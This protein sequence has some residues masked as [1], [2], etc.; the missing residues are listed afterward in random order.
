MLYPPYTI[1]TGVLSLIIMTV[2]RGYRVERRREVCHNVTILGPCVL[3]TT[4]FITE[5][6]SGEG[7][8]VR[9][10]LLSFSIGITNP[11]GVNMFFSYLMTRS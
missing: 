4:T 10:G 6:S 11:L 9:F 8:T 3:H 7:A 2:R 5:T 1:S